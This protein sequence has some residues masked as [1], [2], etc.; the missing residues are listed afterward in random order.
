MTPPRRNAGLQS[1]K[2]ALPI[3]NGPH[4]HTASRYNQLE[5]GTSA[6]VDIEMATGLKDGSMPPTFSL[7]M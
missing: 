4:S 3:G 2:R 6:G 7:E 5:G 1:K